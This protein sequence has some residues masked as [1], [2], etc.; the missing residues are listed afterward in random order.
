MGHSYKG[1]TAKN[2]STSPPLPNPRLE[3]IAMNT[4]GWVY[5][6]PLPDNWGFYDSTDVVPG[7]EEFS[8][9]GSQTETSSSPV[10]GLTIVMRGV[11]AT[12]S[13]FQTDASNVIF[14]A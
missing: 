6:G 5:T 1:G 7:M 11:D 2:E 3:Q 13:F 9:D 10:E 4:L 12:F 14:V 8:V